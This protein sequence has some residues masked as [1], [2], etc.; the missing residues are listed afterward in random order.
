MIIWITVIKKQIMTGSL[1]S[2]LSIAAG[3]I[4]ANILGMI[5]T[6][7]SFGITGNTIAGVFG[8]IL[9]IKSLG[10]LGFDANTIVE[11]GELNMMLLAVNLAI[12]LTGGM[13]AVFIASR[14]K[15]G[16]NKS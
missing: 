11:S 14:I 13:A 2:L 3:I 10:R 7:Y 15:N 5:F 4:G 1:I 6:K 12:S 8:S 9:F 16:M